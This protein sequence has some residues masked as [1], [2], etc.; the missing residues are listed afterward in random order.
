MNS[1]LYFEMAPRLVDPHHGPVCGILG[2]RQC[3]KT[4]LARYY[5]EE[6]QG[7]PVHY[8]DLE[9]PT[10]ISKLESPK[11]IL[12]PLEGLYLFFPPVNSDYL[13]FCQL[14]IFSIPFIGLYSGYLLPN[15]Q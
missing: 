2:P 3:G 8:F 12:E 6:L 14:F 5:A 10:D 7:S 13:Y 4:T 1:L 11:L 9:D 15:S